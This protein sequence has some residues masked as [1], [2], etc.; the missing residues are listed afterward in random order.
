MGSISGQTALHLAV[1]SKQ[2]SLVKMLL[3]YGAKPDIQD[4]KSGKT[5]L[6]IAIEQGNQAIA[7]L[8]LSYGGS[9][10]IPSYSGGT[11]ASLYSE[12]RKMMAIMTQN[13]PMNWLIP[14]GKDSE[15]MK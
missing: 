15:E 1:L 10:S 2:D 12:N 11:P 5:G 8:L 9:V 13:K 4:V 7:E 6:F 3:A 14:K